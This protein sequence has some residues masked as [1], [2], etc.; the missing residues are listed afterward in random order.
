[1]EET[2]D[3]VP[4]WIWALTGGLALLTLLELRPR[5]VS[6]SAL[7]ARRPLGFTRR[8]PP[9]LGTASPRELRALPGIGETR[10]VAIARSR[11]E[12]GPIARPE[13]LE[14]IPGIGP[15][16]VERVRAVLGL[17]PERAPP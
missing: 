16:T 11:F 8:G 14:R 6:E 4:P 7:A 17:Q 12:D 3:S 15:A 9:E 1:M 5:R 10:A 13:D 2:R